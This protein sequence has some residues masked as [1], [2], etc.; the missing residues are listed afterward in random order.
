MV[1]TLRAD[2]VSACGTAGPGT[3]HIDALA[4]GGYLFT[5]VHTAAPTTLASTSSLMTSLYPRMHGALRNDFLLDPSMLTLAEVLSGRGYNTVGFAG[6]Y[7]LHS[8]SGIAQGFSLYD[9]D[10]TGQHGSYEPQRTG[11]EITDA[12][13]A[14]LEN[15]PREPFFLFVHYWD[16][17][18]PYSPPPPFDGTVGRSGDT[19]ITGSM[20]DVRTLKAYLKRGGEVDARCVCMH[21]LYMGE[22]A[23]TDQEIG[24]LTRLLEKHRCLENCLLV[25]T[26]DH[27][28]TF[29][30]H[31]QRGEYFDH[32]YMVYETTTH[33]PLF[34][35]WPGRVPVGESGAVA[36]NIDIAPTIID[37]LGF[38]I[39]ND[40]SG[41]SLMPAIEGKPLRDVPI[42][43]EATNPFGYIEKG[44]VFVNDFKPK[45]VLLG[46]LKLI[47]MPFLDGREELYDTAEDPGENRDLLSEGARAEEIEVL[48]KVLRQWSK[49]G[50]GIAR[51]S[52]SR[53]DAE[54]VM[55]L[56]ALGY[57]L[58]EEVEK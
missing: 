29:W 9:E 46:S 8:S 16:P 39:P 30:E 40:F 45:C 55:R 57:L 31:R 19:G 4:R 26:S 11:A 23:Y 47:W 52:R 24:R 13:A 34:V 17:H 35:R 53:T 58:E 18:A 38:E 28:E 3:P 36:S 54:T 12:V 51:N 2:H 44:A 14:W 33:I 50:S 48:R 5:N 21:D 6:S 10:F 32:G 37:L 1:D 15:T 43:T 49:E 56:R 41:R 25:F 20:A 7:S 22:I 27:G 42:F